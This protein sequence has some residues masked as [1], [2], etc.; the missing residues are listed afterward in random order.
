VLCPNAHKEQSIVG[1]SDGHKLQ[2][3]TFSISLGYGNGRLAHQDKARGKL[4]QSLTQ[5]PNPA[6][7]TLPHISHQPQK[8]CQGDLFG[9]GRLPSDL[10]HLHPQLLRRH[11]ATNTD[12]DRFAE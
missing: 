5:F 1:K 4:L 12:L 10:P 9:T 11:E 7:P 8:G 6:P 3:D 2:E